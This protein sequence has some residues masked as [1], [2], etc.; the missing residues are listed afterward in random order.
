M[1]NEGTEAPGS[2]TEYAGTAAETATVSGV[3]TTDFDTTIALADVTVGDLLVIYSPTNPQNVSVVQVTAK[4]A[5]AVPANANVQID[6]TKTPLL[7]NVAIG[8]IIYKANQIGLGNASAT[9]YF[10]VQVL[11]L[12]HST[13]RPVGFN[14]WKAAISGGLEYSFSSDNFA[15]T[16]LT[17]KVL[18]PSAAEYGVGGPLN[19]VSGLMANHP[20]GFFFRG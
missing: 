17:F 18:Q 4:A 6:N 12:D 7:F 2:V 13:G 1:I 10:A 19:H 9:N 16:P 14:F 5:A 3:G 8:D 15:S 11:G 20:Y